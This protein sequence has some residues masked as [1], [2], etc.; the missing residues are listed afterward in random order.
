VDVI[1]EIYAEVDE[2]NVKE[3][4]TD[5]DNNIQ[6]IMMDLG[7]KLTPELAQEVASV[8]NLNAKFAFYNVCFTKAYEILTKVDSKIASVFSAIQDTNVF[9]VSKFTDKLLSL[10][11]TITDLIQRLEEVEHEKKGGPKS[12]VK[13]MEE[14]ILKLKQENMNAMDK[15]IRQSK[16]IDRL[17][18]DRDQKIPAKNKPEN[19]EKEHRPSHK[20]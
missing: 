2:E 19:E 20:R 8:Y 14:E 10:H 17:K 13:Q 5:I 7:N 6:S 1:K 3:V 4:S 11:P 18:K 9:V 15:I 16:E 12:S